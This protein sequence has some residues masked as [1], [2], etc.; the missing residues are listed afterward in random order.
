MTTGGWTCSCQTHRAMASCATMMPHSSQVASCVAWPANWAR[1][2]VRSHF[3][4]CPSSSDASPGGGNGVIP[5][6]YQYFRG[7]VSGFLKAA[8]SFR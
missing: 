3:L 1:A 5:D 7:T 2:I 8:A 6:Q 4:L